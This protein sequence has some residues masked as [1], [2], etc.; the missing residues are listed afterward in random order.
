V[1]HLN[2]PLVKNVRQRQTL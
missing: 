2:M 1:D